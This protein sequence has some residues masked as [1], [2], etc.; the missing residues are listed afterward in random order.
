MILCKTINHP[1]ILRR[2][3]LF[4]LRRIQPSG[5]QKTRIGA[6]MVRCIQS[7]RHPETRP[8]VRLTK[9]LAA[10]RIPPHTLCGG[11]FLHFI[12]QILSFILTCAHTIIYARTRHA[13]A[14]GAQHPKHVPKISRL[15][16]KHA[17]FCRIEYFSLDKHN[18][19]FYHYSE[20]GV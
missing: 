18:Q 6:S 14:K 16:T 3:H 17:L 20:F 5:A 15:I 8:L 12:L 1:V 10:R 4:G 19:L 9:D 7:S 13:C 2:A 11:V